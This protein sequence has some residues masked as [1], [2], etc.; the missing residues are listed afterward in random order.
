MSRSPRSWSRPARPPRMMPDQPLPLASLPTDHRPT[1]ANTPA[2]P[3]EPVASGRRPVPIEGSSPLIGS[4]SEQTHL[5][6][7]QKSRHT[8]HGTKQTHPPSRQP[9]LGRSR[10][11]SRSSI[12]RNEPSALDVSGSPVIKS[13]NQAGRSKAHRARFGRVAGTHWPIGTEQTQPPGPNKPNRSPSSRNEPRSLD[14]SPSPPSGIAGNLGAPRGAP[15]HPGRSPRPASAP[16][17]PGSADHA[18]SGSKQ[19]QFARARFPK[20]TADDSRS[21]VQDVV[22]AIRQGRTGAHR[23]SIRVV[24]KSGSSPRFEG[25]APPSTPLGVDRPCPDR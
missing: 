23:T 12:S 4:E 8:L 20:R 15:G 24:R 9:T 21:L 22:Y 17:S 3:R 6:K 1:R 14:A 7:G 11:G 25:H 18:T 5:P 2:R 19:T 13:V 10:T 16:R